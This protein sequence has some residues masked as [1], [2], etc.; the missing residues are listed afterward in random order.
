MDDAGSRTTRDAWARLATPGPILAL[1]I[2]VGTLMRLYRFDAPILDS[3]GFRQTQTASIVWLWERDG[4]DLL[5]YRIPMFGGGHWVL[6]FPT[7]EV[8]VFG[9]S[10]PFGGI[11]ASGRI[12]SIASYIFATVLL[13]LVA[14]RFTGSRR[15]GVAAAAIFTLLPATVFYF[16]A[17]MIDPFVIATT[18]LA[19]YAAI[20]LVERFTWIWWAIFT[21][22]LAVAVLGK[23]TIVLATGAALVPLGIRALAA[24]GRGLR[25]RGAIVAS[26]AVTL[27]LLGLWT[28]HGDDLNRA[29]HGLTVSSAPEWFFGSTFTRQALWDTVIGRF[30][31]NLQLAGVILVAIGLIAC[32]TRVRTPYRPEIAATIAGAAISIGVFANLNTIHDYYQLP[33][34]VPLSM[35]AGL[36]LAVAHAEL[37]RFTRVGAAVAAAGVIVALGVAWS[38]VTWDGYF[39]PDAVA[40]AYQGQGVEL[41][42]AT[43]DARLIVVEEN[44]DVFAPMLWYESRRIGWRVRTDDLAT[45]RRLATTIP[46]LGGIVFL[47]G[48]APEPQ[49]IAGA[50]AAR[51]F[52]RTCESPGMVVYTA[53]RPA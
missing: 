41:A 23:P 6:E 37:T 48:A 4:L 13:H 42:N 16:R 46:D 7:Y 38:Q 49:A 52:Q 20:R 45:L 11:E 21:A 9:L 5:S 29:S 43:P 51:G 30:R 34:Y 8:L 24:P 32:V 26:G 3:H 12:V 47:R 53:P 14:T 40:Y 22:A 19:V 10:R 33:Y 15:A 1:V 44:A 31:D 18:L 50:A 27:V 25:E 17:V 28:R 39:G 2:A 35:L 36:G